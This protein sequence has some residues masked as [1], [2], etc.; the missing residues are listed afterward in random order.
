MENWK[1]IVICDG[2]LESVNVSKRVLYREITISDTMG[3][4]DLCFCGSG[5]KHK[6]C[7]S[8][9]YEKSIIAQLLAA[10]N[11]IDEKIK[12]RQSYTLCCKGCKDCCSNYFKVSITEFFSILY[13][14]KGDLSLIRY[15]DEAKKIIKN[16]VLSKSDLE[17]IIDFPEC[18]FVDDYSGEC[19]IYHVRPTLCRD[20][21][22]VTFIYWFSTLDENGDLKTQRLKSLFSA[23]FTRPA[24]EFVKILLIP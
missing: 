22:S 15:S 14:L 21:G 1:G 8:E 18:I 9:V 5:K 17:N 20:Y 12:E 2:N 4:N 23:F 3:A 10:Y 6:R 7:H 19:K 24:S 13:S 16:A 11:Q